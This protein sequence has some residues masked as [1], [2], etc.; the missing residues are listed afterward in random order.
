MP[1]LLHWLEEIIACSAL[2][3]V[4]LAVVWGVITRYITAQPAAWAAEVAAIAFAWCVF[5]GAA[6]GVKRGAHV[7]ID[8]LV[9]LLPQA[10][11][12]VVNR[13]AALVALGFC[14]ATTVMA[15]SFAADNFD[16]PSAVLRLPLSVLYAALVA[17][18]GLMTLRSFQAMLGRPW[19][20]TPRA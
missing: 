11:Q 16:N 3:I 1:R 2:V 10:A 18:F 19:Q 4:V 5:V 13:G 9:M 6:A 8:M 15:A 14:A 20:E 12:R 17:G 7:S